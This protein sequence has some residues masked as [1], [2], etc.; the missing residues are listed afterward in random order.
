MMFTFSS[1][2]LLRL[3]I[4]DAV[5]KKAFVCENIPKPKPLSKKKKICKKPRPKITVNDLLEHVGI[6]EEEYNNM[7]KEIELSESS[8]FYDY[9]KNLL[10]HGSFHWRIKSRCENVVVLND[11]DSESGKIKVKITLTVY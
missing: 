2:Y 8:V 1:L 9:K 5:I 3:N 10:I 6:D 7:K 11:F 4:L